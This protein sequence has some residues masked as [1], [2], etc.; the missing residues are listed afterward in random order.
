MRKNT[1]TGGRVKIFVGG[2]VLSDVMERQ[3]RFTDVKEAIKS[4]LEGG[5][6]PGCGSVLLSIGREL[7]SKYPEDEIA[8]KLS[9]VFSYQYCHLMDVDSTDIYDVDPEGIVYT[10]L[11]TGE[12]AN[13]P[14]EL[15]I[16]DTA[17]ALSNALR[18]GHKTASLLINLSGVLLGNNLGRQTIK[19]G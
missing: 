11:A 18:A 1:L 16:Y 6:I 8:I 12:H 15:G 3:D 7:R 19:I 14:E 5:I 13:N 10:N 2:D 9:D 4:A 17:G